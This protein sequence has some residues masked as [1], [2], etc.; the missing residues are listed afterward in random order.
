M[1]KLFFV[2]VVGIC[3]AAQA[4]EFDV[5]GN[6][7]SE[8]GK[9]GLPKGWTFHMWKGYLPKPTVGVTEGDAKGTRALF[10]KDVRGNDGAAVMTTAKRPGAGGD[11]VAVGFTARGRGKAWVTLV[12]STEKGG[13]NQ[14]EAHAA[15]DL[16]DE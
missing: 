12:R 9:N 14:T 7:A 3:A 6:F 16:T 2:V 1:R 11:R 15:I 5:Y 8:I 4:A 13:W 10:V